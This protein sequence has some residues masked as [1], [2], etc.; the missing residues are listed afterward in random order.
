MSE[1]TVIIINTLLYVLFFIWIL[2]K[3]KWN[4]LATLLAI[5]YTISAISSLLFY[6]QP[7]YQYSFTAL[8][9]AQLPACIY[10]FCINALF[11]SAF[12]HF[13]LS[14]I[15]YLKGYNSRLLYNIERLL[16]IIVVII[17][18]FSLP[19]SISTFFSG[20]N[21]ADMRADI[22]GGNS[23]SSYFLIA[24]FKRL[25]SS[26]VLPMFIIACIRILLVKER[27]FWDKFAIYLYLIF[28]ANTVLSAIARA[29]IIF[30]VIELLCVFVLF[31]S[32]I[33]HRHKKR[34]LKYTLIFIPFFYLTFNAIS[35]ARFGKNGIAESHYHT[36]RYAGE[37]QLNFMALAYPN[38]QIPFKG[39]NQF[40]LFRR[41]IGLP[42]FK[43][44]KDVEGV[45]DP[46][47]QSKFKYP[48]PTFIFY[49]LAGDVYLN[50]GWTGSI[51]IA[52]IFNFMINGLARRKW[53]SVTGLIV[54]IM[55]SAYVAKGIFYADYQFESGN[56]LIIYLLLL[57]LILKRTRF[58]V[59]I[60]KLHNN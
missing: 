3:Y 42:Y 32:Y 1:L 5:F 49:S 27:S 4:N 39:Y 52:F 56:L 19:K 59:E 33:S 44:F 37:P 54:C 47:I 28:Q 6:L 14:K 11:I 58:L 2:A 16:C 7:L 46:Y 36:L 24:L 53:I 23:E 9:R 57:H 48:H 20:A 41:L 60:G 31:I 15:K 8:G 34:I 25:F 55:M 18:I 13:D 30:S 45:Y 26:C 17:L 40:T 29:T 38:L 51:I 22:A 50:W 10:L 12:R 35:Y 43:T 21:F